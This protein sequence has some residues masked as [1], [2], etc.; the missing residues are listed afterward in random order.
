MILTKE[1]RSTVEFLHNEMP[2]FIPPDLWPPCSPDLNP[3]NYKIWGCMQERMY[4][5]PICDL[6]ELK[7]RL[8]KVW[9][10]L[11]QTIVDEAI[12]Q[13]TKR[14][15]ACVKPK[16]NILNIYYNFSRMCRLRVPTF[17]DIKAVFL[18]L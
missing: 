10:D 9:A 14:L 4:N 6:A 3:V 18:K 16:D 1:E 5:K 13:W 15:K 12:D 17:F 8:V 11:E 7:Q 2:D